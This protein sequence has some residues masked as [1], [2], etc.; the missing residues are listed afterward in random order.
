MN[1]PFYTFTTAGSPQRLFAQAATEGPNCVIFANCKV[2]VTVQQGQ[3]TILARLRQRHTV[4]ILVQRVKGHRLTR[5]G[6]VPLGSHRKGRLRK[7]WDLK[8][9]GKQLRPGRYRITLRA[10]DRRGDVLGLSKPVTIRVH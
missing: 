8:V 9:G 4:G 10:L 7:S 3:A 6:R 1:A 2:A 5:V